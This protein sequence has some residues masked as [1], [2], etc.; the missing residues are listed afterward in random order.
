MSEWELSEVK[1]HGGTVYRTVDIIAHIKH[2]PTCEVM[3]CK[4]EEPVFE[5]E[6]APSVF[7]WE[8][9]N[10]S[11]DCNREIFFREEKGEEYRDC[12]C[13]DGVYSV[14]LENANTGEIYYREY[15]RDKES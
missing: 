9:N 15:G 8:D 13:S 4:R 11:C 2:N 5:G 12:E 7:N 14:N 10:Y 6:T 3:S 1:K